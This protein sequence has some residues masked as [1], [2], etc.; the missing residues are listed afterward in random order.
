MDQTVFVL[1]TGTLVSSCDSCHNESMCQESQERGDTFSG[2]VL[3]CVCKDGFLG[4]GL[5]C[6]DTK[7]CSDSSCCSRGYHW[8][9]DSGL[10]ET[11]AVNRLK[12]IN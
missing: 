1:F 6:Y 9:P 5:T 4:D 12:K 7:L 2:P 8:S 3:S 11:R 10:V